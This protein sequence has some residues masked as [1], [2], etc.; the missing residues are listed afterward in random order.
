M[1][2]HV[3]Q[4][5]ETTV[6]FSFSKNVFYPNQTFF[7]LDFTLFSLS[8]FDNILKQRYYI[9]ES[10]LFSLIFSYLWQWFTIYS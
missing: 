3:R 6:V 2:M 8:A 1:Q 7:P 4:G 9:G 10:C 5:I